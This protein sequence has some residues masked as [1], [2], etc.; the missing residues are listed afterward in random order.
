MKSFLKKNWAYI[1]FAVTLLVGHVSWML[2]VE[3]ALSRNDRVEN[4]E[5]LIEP[6]VRQHIFEEELT[7]RGLPIPVPHHEHPEYA[8]RDHTHTEAPPMHM[9]LPAND[10][11]EGEDLER[12][13]DEA[14]QKARDMIQRP[15]KR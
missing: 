7:A 2:H 6:L 1:T 11:P 4:V 14:G 3:V 10:E 12:I 15:M 9:M 13:Y 8:L 5:Q